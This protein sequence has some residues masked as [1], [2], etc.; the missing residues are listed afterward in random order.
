M[1]IL[2]ILIAAGA[3]GLAALIVVAIS[4]GSFSEAGS[5]LMSDPW[6][7]VT[8]ADLYL[9]FVLAAAVIWLCE[10]RPLVAVLWILPIPVLGNV[11]AAVWFILRLPHLRER[12]ARR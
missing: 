3:L 4:A 5:W 11:W 1:K 12:I 10:P 8:L 2:Q 9:G 6:G 7:R